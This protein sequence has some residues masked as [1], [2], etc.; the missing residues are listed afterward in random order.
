LNLTFKTLLC[1]AQNMSATEMDKNFDKEPA[2]PTYHPETP[3][4]EDG[5]AQEVKRARDLQHRT[6]ALRSLRRGEEW[7]DEKMGVESQGIDRIP[8]EKKQPPSVINVS[9]FLQVQL[10]VPRLAITITPDFPAVVFI[11]STR[12]C[13]TTWYSWP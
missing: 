7:L 1:E 12:R 2:A 8:D 9:V 5:T 10:S 13:C 11:E 3:D 4:L 6:K